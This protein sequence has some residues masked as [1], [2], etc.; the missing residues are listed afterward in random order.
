MKTSIDIDDALLDRVRRRA[1]REGVT[2][3]Q[4]VESGLRLTLSESATRQPPKPF[5]WPVA[6]GMK[7][8]PLINQSINEMIDAVRDERLNRI[9]NS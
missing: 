1:K 6:S 7:A 3:K 4:M 2:I 8:Q 9:Q 5:V